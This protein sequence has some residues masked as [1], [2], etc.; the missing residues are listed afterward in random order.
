MD[1]NFATLAWA[2]TRYTLGLRANR[3]KNHFFKS[4]NLILPCID[5]IVDVSILILAVKENCQS[6]KLSVILPLCISAEQSA[7]G[8][9]GGDSWQL[10]MTADRERCGPQLGRD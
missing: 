5:G 8:A 10:V 4:K 1:I 6:I 9:V 3:C 7:G 2:V